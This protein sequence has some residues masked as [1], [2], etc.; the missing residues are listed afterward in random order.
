MTLTLKT[1][2]ALL[3][4]SLVAGAAA[5]VPTA[6]FSYDPA[7]PAAETYAGFEKAAR[8]ACRSD[9]KGLLVKSREETA[10]RA[11][12][13]DRIVAHVGT[14]E[15]AALHRTQSGEAEPVREFAVAN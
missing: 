5:A 4:A 2:A 3:A 10:C 1:A 14:T 12:M 13:M 15:L 6:T 11:D 7:Q 9:A 8:K